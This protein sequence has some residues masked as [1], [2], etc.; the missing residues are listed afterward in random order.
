M[1]FGSVIKELK[2]Q[3]ETSNAGSRWS[4]EENEQLLEE[5]KNN[6]SYEDIAK[7]HKRTIT[8]IK[9]HVICYVIFPIYNIDEIESKIDEISEKYNIEPE[10]IIRYVKKQIKNNENIKVVNKEITVNKRLENIE[11]I[12]IKLNEQIDKITS[13]F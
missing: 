6:K 8:A 1:P 5:L 7:N 2:N 12:L 11:N 4:D 3:L 13:L 10:I 9:A